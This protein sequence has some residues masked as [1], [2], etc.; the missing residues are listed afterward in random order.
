M[1]VHFV[2]NKL[3]NQYP[4][5]TGNVMMYVITTQ[6]TI[7]LLLLLT[8]TLNPLLFLFVQSR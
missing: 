5:L 3:H 7:S 2:K 6:F 1:V 4:C 8:V